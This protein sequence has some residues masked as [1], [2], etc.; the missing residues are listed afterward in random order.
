AIGYVYS[1]IN[2]QNKN[3]ELVNF[4][5]NEGFAITIYIGEGRDSNRYKYEILTKRN[6]EAELF[7]IVQQFEPNAF[8]ISYEPKSF[9]GGFLLD[10]MKE[11]YK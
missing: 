11:K 2:T 9:K 10:R 5:R 8:I 7:Q 1:T 3:E 6:R 4:L